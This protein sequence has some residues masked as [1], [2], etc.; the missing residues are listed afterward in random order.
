ME[1]ISEEIRFNDFIELINPN[2]VFKFGNGRFYRDGG[3]IVNVAM[4]YDKD[5]KSMIISFEYDNVWE[6]FILNYEKN[7]IYF[8]HFMDRMQCIYIK[9]NLIIEF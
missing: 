3:E 8:V 4:F 2:N 7:Y 9:N 5:I 6:E 1:N